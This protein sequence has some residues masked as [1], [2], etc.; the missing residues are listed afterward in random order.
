M[1]TIS[2]KNDDGESNLGFVLE[3]R[4]HRLQAS[5]TK[6]RGKPPLSAELKSVGSDVAR[7]KGLK[8]KE[9]SSYLFSF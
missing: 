4:C 1:K 2:K 7:V 8:R 3:R 6:G 9:A 5:L